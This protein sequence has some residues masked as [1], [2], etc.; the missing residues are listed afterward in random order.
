MFKLDWLKRPFVGDQ[1]TGRFAFQRPMGLVQSNYRGGAGQTV[2][3]P[4]VAAS[5]LVFAPKTVVTSDPTVTGN[6]ADTLGNES[7]SNPQDNLIKTGQL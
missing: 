5:P 7:L 6:P 4:L 2:R 1:N 3:R